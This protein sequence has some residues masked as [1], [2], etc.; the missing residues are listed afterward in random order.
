L[1]I[2]DKG[3]KMTSTSKISSKKEEQPINPKNVWES[4]LGK[5]LLDP[6]S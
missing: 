3:G 2:F 5:M 6:D 1:I 4:L